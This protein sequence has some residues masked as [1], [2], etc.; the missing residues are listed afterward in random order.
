MKTVGFL[1][2]DISNVGGTQK[3]TS[4]LSN[5]FYRYGVCKVVIFTLTKKT[6]PNFVLDERVDI[7]NLN[8]EY[9]K[10]NLLKIA[11]LVNKNIA[12]TNVDI[13]IGIGVYLSI[14]LPLIN[15]KTIACEH[16]SYDIA[17]RLTSLVRFISYRF[18]DCVVSLTSEDQG[19]LAK[20]NSNTIVIPNPLEFNFSEISL[21]SPRDNTVI[22]VGSL[23]I[24]KGIDRLLDIWSTV[25]KFS[26]G[27]TLKICG[28]GVEREMLEK[29]CI[30]L[31]LN[32][33]AFLGNVNNIKDELLKAKVFVLTSH[34]E[35]FPMVLLEAMGCGVPCLSF[36]IK[37]G[38]KEIIENDKDGYII[39]DGQNDIY[40]EKL[41]DIIGSPSLQREMS[42]NS[43]YNIQRYSLRGVVAK[44]EGVFGNI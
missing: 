42:I 29:K 16:N 36:N 2:S 27:Y 30:D 25:E 11:K 41:L 20:I 22:T 18:V 15:C 44:W 9:S 12:T 32:S 19:K 35:G 3:V 1:I 26:S 24:R 17:S 5:A 14:I 10:S 21:D 13:L 4:L 7:V 23:D 8:V 28:D 6:N 37:T 39:E 40:A 31:G 33:V 34:K 43:F 38:P